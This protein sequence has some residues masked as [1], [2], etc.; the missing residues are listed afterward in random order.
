LDNGCNPLIPDV[1]ITV[2]VLDTT[3]KINFD[4]RDSLIELISVLKIIF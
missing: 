4:L 2:S 1:R 3:Y